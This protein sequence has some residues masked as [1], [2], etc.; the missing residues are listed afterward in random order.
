MSRKRG[1]PHV[2]GARGI[3]PTEW[4]APD[5]PPRG[6]P[7]CAAFLSQL[8]VFACAQGSR[9]LVFFTRVG[10][11]SIRM[12]VSPG[13]GAEKKSADRCGSLAAC[14]CIE[15]NSEGASALYAEPCSRLWARCP[16]LVSRQTQAA[17][18]VTALWLQLLMP[19]PYPPRSTFIAAQL[20]DCSTPYHPLIPAHPHHHPTGSSSGASSS[21]WIP[22]R[23]W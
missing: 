23:W 3:L 18:A 7:C 4:S 12:A 15:G 20:V 17:A 8:C 14:L 9:P 5:C 21:S 22:T 1:R 16:P 11:N 10:K 6:V 19:V 2:I 13:A